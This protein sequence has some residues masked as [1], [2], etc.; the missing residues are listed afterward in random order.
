MGA[1]LGGRAGRHVFENLV[2]DPTVKTVFLNKRL[3]DPSIQTYTK[4]GTRLS[5]TDA[6]SLR[7]LYDM[8]IRMIASFGSDFDNL[9]GVNRIY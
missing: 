8:K 5:F 7:V 2:H 4:Y 1:R 6:A 9:E 3:M